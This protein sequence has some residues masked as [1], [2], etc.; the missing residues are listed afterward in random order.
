LKNIR[1]NGTVRDI[2]LKLRT[3]AGRLIDGLIPAPSL[4]ARGKVFP[5][6]IDRCDCSKANGSKDQASDSA[7]KLVDLSFAWRSSM[8]TAGRQIQHTNRQF[9]ELFGIPLSP[10]DMVGASCEQAA[11]MS[12]DKFKNSDQFT[13]RIH[14]IVREK[15]IVLNEELQMTDGRTLLRDYVPVFT[16]NNE[17]EHLWFYRDVT[18]RKRVEKMFE[19]QSALQKIL[20]HISSEYI[21]PIEKLKRSSINR[22][23]N[24]AF[25]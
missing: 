16:S 9:C 24:W 15:K 18:E 8:E 6:G 2:E 23:E 21:N 11:Q 10:E 17:T 12:K 13:D 3:K 20:M 1:E 14:Q 25:W 4:K 5:F 19:S 22:S 7:A